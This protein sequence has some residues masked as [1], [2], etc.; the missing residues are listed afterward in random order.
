MRVSEVIRR[1]VVAIVAI[2]ALFVVLDL[3]LRSANARPGNPIVGYV[4]EAADLATP[5]AAATMFV[6]QQR[7]QTV[8]ITLLMYLIVGIAATLVV[9][10]LASA[11]EQ[12]DRRG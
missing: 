5:S 9:H 12:P 11:F 8:A 4:R 10:G 3:L 1:T 7:W 2:P 6:D